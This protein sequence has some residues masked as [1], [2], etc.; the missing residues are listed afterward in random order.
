MPHKHQ[1]ASA[2][3]PA[4]AHE[5]NQPFELREFFRDVVRSFVPS[6]YARLAAQPASTAAFYLGGVAFLVTLLLTPLIYVEQEHMRSIQREHNERIL[7]DELYF[8]SGTADYEGEQP[9][10]HVETSADER[11]VYI[12]DTTGQTT[13]VPA[14][15]AYGMLITRDK[16]IETVHTREGGNKTVDSPIPETEGR[17]RAKVFFLNAIDRERWPALANV[18]GFLFLLAVVSLFALATL[19]AA[20]SAALEATRKENRVPFR[21]C[22]AVA[23]HAA[24]PVAFVAASRLAVRTVPQ[25][26]LVVGVP[27]VAFMLLVSLGMQTCR[28]SL[29]ARP[30]A[31]E[32][33]PE[34]KRPR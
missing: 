4:K 5:H 6:A 34:A 18:V 17:T 20:L 27:L 31:R 16:I 14:E 25:F 7:P 32:A 8:E 15:Y 33:R 28:R 13:E 30:E 22:F 24:T 2:Q 26:Y 19:V 3:K 1:G 11:Y 29:E 10:V 12:V 23:T 21:A 9:Y